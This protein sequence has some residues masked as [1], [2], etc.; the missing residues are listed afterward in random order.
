MSLPS[1]R[2]L[3]IDEMLP[4]PR[5]TISLTRRCLPRQNRIQTI[6]QILKRQLN[7]S[8]SAQSYET[9]GRFPI[10]HGPVGYSI[11]FAKGLYGAEGGYQ[12]QCFD[13]GG[14]G[15]FEFY[16]GLNESFVFIE[17]TEDRPSLVSVWCP[18][19]YV[20]DVSDREIFQR[21]GEEVW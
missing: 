11:V 8:L 6:S 7:T 14:Q 9:S 18:V 10:T 15:G 16:K 20:A 4:N 3:H 19:S 2:S 5:R 13:L 1:L 12:S 21:W 17:G